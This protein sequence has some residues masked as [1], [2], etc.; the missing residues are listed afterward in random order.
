M[1]FA[2]LVPRNGLSAFLEPRMR[3]NGDSKYANGV[4]GPDECR[5][6]FSRAG[7]LACA[8]RESAMFASIMSMFFGGGSSNPDEV[9]WG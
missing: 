1:S 3:L 8:A 2:P 4:A 7:A 6:F 9:I 5:Y